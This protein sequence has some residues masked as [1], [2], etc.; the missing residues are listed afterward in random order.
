[1]TTPF[2]YCQI[3]DGY[4]GNGAACSHCG[5]DAGSPLRLNPKCEISGEHIYTV[6]EFLAALK[7]L[8]PTSAQRLEREISKAGSALLGLE[9]RARHT[10][11]GGS[12][13]VTPGTVEEFVCEEL[14]TR[15]QVLF[16]T[17]CANLEFYRG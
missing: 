1:M 2:P 14:G 11:T 3:C 16:C 10:I 5:N 17:G 4:G 8:K 7:A 13:C 6:A 9:L 12:C 15:F